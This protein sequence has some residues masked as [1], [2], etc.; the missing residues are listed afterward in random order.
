MVK[1]P[2]GSFAMGSPASRGGANEPG[3]ATSYIGFRL[4]RG[5]TQ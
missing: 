1:I 2:G 5:L 3:F 4:V